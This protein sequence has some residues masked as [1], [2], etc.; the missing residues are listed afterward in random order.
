MKSKKFISR[1]LVLL[2]TVVM[3]STI[4]ACSDTATNEDPDAEVKEEI[5]Y[6]DLGGYDFHIL[7]YFRDGVAELA[8]QVGDSVLGDKL[9]EHYAHVGELFNCTVT[10]EDTNLKHVTM[11]QQAALSGTKA[12][13]IGD[14]FTG[15]ILS[16]Y[17][18]DYLITL[19]EVVDDP[20][21]GK[22]GT[23]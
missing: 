4:V 9:L 19:N 10:A 11:V 15:E 17:K 5:E 18:G 22:Y 3:F 20:F 13:D 16:L 6:V 1:F 14:A 12:G 21:I 8:P 2:L 23:A 7:G